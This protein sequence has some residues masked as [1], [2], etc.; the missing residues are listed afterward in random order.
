M[1]ALKL[2]IYL[3]GA[4]LIGSFAVQNMD[5]VEVNYYDFRLNL[6]TLEL[7]LVTVVMIPLGLGLFGAWCMWLLSWIKMRMVIRKKNK[8]ISAMEEELEKLRNTP[9]ISAQVESYTE[10]DNY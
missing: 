7:P 1:P 2:I 3:I 5:S 8:T 9:Q 4:I 10:M 6:H